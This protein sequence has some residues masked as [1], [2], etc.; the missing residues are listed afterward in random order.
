MY[1]VLTFSDP[2]LLH[3]LFNMIPPLAKARPSLAPLLVSSVTQWTPAAL[4]KAGKPPSQIRAVEKTVKV[5][6]VHLSR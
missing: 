1:T 6:M 5:V 4:D 3:P 2:A